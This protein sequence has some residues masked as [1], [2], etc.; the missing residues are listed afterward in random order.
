MPFCKNNNS[1]IYD[2]NE[3]SPKG[4]G[5]CASSENV[6][7]KMKGKDGNIWKVKKIS[8]G[9]RRW[10]KEKSKNNTKKRSRTKT[11]TK[12][13]TNTKSKRKSRTR[14]KTKS[15]KMSRT[16]RR[17]KTKSKTKSKSKSKSKG[18]K[19]KKDSESKYLDMDEIDCKKFVRYEKKIS[20]SNSKLRS[21]YL[22]KNLSGLENREGYL[23]LYKS[24]NI[25]E[26]KETKIPKNYKKKRVSSEFIKEYYCN[27]KL[28]SLNPD[29]EEIKKLSLKHK[30]DKIYFSHDNGDR[31]FRIVISGNNVYIYRIPKDR[32]IISDNW[33]KIDPYE[34]KLKSPYIENILT[35][36]TKNIFIGKS[37]K[38]ETTEMSHGSGKY[39]DGNSILLNI[40]NNE[41]IF[42]GTNIYSLQTD[43]KILRFFSP[44][45]NNDVPYPVA[46]GEKNVYF[47]LDLVY[48]P[49]DKFDKKIKHESD[50]YGLF[51]AGCYSNTKPKKFKKIKIIQKRF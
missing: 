8:T 5:Y 24:L 28:S 46:I 45:G 13:R 49:I 10:V 7:K 32:F 39:F 9:I 37:L 30:N 43:D 25:F 19:I 48:I 38:C 27:S 17:T 40:K 41:Y 47:M 22:I 18:K 35:T 12:T 21:S 20:N 50:Y 26:R 4:L 34:E 1:K 44:V 15:K 33:K 51:Y 23:N 42:I 6:G 16:R 36:K 3:P 11:R 31:P 2:G 29:D 14:T